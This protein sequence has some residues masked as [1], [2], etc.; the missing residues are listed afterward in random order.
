MGGIFPQNNFL[1]FWHSVKKNPHSAW[2]LCIMNYALC[3]MNY[4]LL[5]AVFVINFMVGVDLSDKL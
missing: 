5:L 1:S 2:Q 3:I 4:E